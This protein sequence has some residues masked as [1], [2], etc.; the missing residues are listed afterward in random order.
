MAKIF[1]IS[2]HGGAKMNFLFNGLNL[3]LSFLN[4]LRAK[5]RVIASNIAN[6]ETPFYKKLKVELIQIDSELPLK[7]TNPHHISNQP[8]T[9]FSYQILQENSSL[10][11]E[12][13][14]NV[15]V[16]EEL[17]QL[18]KVALKYESTLKFINGK[19]NALELVIKSGGQ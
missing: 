7:K 9:P 15:N 6:A 8:S 16:E 19:F 12:D 3:Y 5:D 14:N 1:K 11:G 13:K 10:I 4:Y 17:A 18:E 2:F